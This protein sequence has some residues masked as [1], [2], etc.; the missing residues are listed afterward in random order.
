[1]T[2]LPEIKRVVNPVDKLRDEMAKL[3]DSAHA[4]VNKLVEVAEFDTPKIQEVALISYTLETSPSYALKVSKSGWHRDELSAPQTAEE[5]QKAFDRFQ[6]NHAA[7]LI[8]IEE[9]HKANIPAMEINGRAA[10][11]VK[12][13]MEAVGIPATY[14]TWSYKT[15]RSRSRTETR[16]SAGWSSDISRLIRIADGYD[17]AIKSA[18]ANLKTM[19]EFVTKKIQ[20]LKTQ[21]AEAA[22]AKA[23]VEADAAAAARAMFYRVKYQCSPTAVMDE[24]LDKILDRDKYLMLGHYLHLNRLDWSDGHDYASTG[25]DNFTIETDD[26]QTI[27]NHIEQLIENWDEDGRVFR[28]SQYGYDYLYSLVDAELRTDYDNVWAMVTK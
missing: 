21:E 6:E 26:D 14:S 7:E 17:N 15:S 2:K 13:V 12:R 28:D 9:V 18:A 19:T 16:H 10:Q 23:K 20:E 24:V 4:Q 27:Y 1:M 22:K 3:L 11:A 25:L 8:R 5:W